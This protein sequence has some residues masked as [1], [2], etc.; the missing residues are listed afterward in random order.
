ML[1]TEKMCI[2]EDYAEYKEN[3]TFYFTLFSV[4]WPL[5]QKDSLNSSKKLEHP[6]TVLKVFINS[7]P[8]L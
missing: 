7:F 6:N 5:K 2:L 3:F 8:Q 1:Q 4:I